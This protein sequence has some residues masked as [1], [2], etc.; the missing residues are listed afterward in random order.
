MNA[1]SKD[2]QMV[3]DEG[4]SDGL[5]TEQDVT[6]LSTYSQSTG[7]TDTDTGSSEG[8]NKAGVD[9]AVEESEVEA[10]AGPEVAT[11]QAI[12]QNPKEEPVESEVAKSINRHT[13]VND[14]Q[15]KSDQTIHSII[16]REVDDAYENAADSPNGGKSVM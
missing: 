12:G 11:D 1:V 4:S 5:G 7:D 13:G 3:G 10:I 16:F 15:F 6:S 14:G 9:A 2:A 8:V